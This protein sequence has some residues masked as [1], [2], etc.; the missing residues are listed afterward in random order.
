MGDARCLCL[1]LRYRHPGVR[2]SKPHCTQIFPLPFQFSYDLS[3]PTEPN[4]ALKA[5]KP[6]DMVWTHLIAAEVSARN[7]DRRGGRHHVLSFPT[8]P[9][10][11]VVS[12]DVP[13]NSGQQASLRGHS[14]SNLHRMHA[15]LWL[16]APQLGQG[17]PDPCWGARNLLRRRSQNIQDGVSPADTTPHLPVR[18][19]VSEAGRSR[20]SCPV[21][22]CL[23]QDLS[24]KC[25]EAKPSRQKPKALVRRTEKAY[26]SLG[27]WPY[28]MR[29]F[30][31]FN[32]R[33]G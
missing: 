19:R 20:R 12:F 5:P 17:C 26:P 27:K 10:L 16:Q 2:K 11:Y 15:I 14:P 13:N 18:T 24:G 31:S 28:D 4:P 21:V 8:A 6:E 29:D 25:F 23:R 7:I 22:R 1:C 32:A 30:N 9:A 33:D 3:L